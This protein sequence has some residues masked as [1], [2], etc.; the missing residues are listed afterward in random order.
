MKFRYINNIALLGF[1]FTACQ[2][3]SLSYKEITNNTISF[4][5]TVVEPTSLQTR[6]PS[7]DSTTFVTHDAF[8]CDFYLQLD[9]Q[10]SGQEITEF[11]TYVVPSTYEGRLDV[12]NI[13]GES[14][15]TALSWKSLRGEHTFYGWTFPTGGKQGYNIDNPFAN[16]SGEEF[17]EVLKNGVEITFNN[18]SEGK[19]YDTYNN[20]AIY[21]QFIGTQKGP[22]T[23]V[24]N[25]TYV[26]LIFKHLVSKIYVDEIV[27][28]MFGSIEEHLQANMTIY[29]LPTKATFYPNPKLAIDFDGE[30][31][32]NDGGPVVVP[33]VNPDDEMTFYIENDSK[34]QDYVWICP[35]V[36]FSD[37]SF[38]V[39]L[40]STES[41]YNGLKDFSGTFKNVIFDRTG[42]NWD[43][44]K[45]GDETVLHAGEMM[46]LK[47]ILYPGGD[48]GLYVK[49]LPW[50]THDPEDT[51]HYSHAGLYSDSSLNEIAAAADD[52]EKA[53]ELFELYGEE[54]TNEDGTVEKVFNLYENTDLTFTSGNMNVLRVT[55]DYVLEGNGH[56]I[57]VNKSNVR[58]R[59]VRNVYITDC[60][61]KYI[62]IDPDGKLYRVDPNTF[63]TIGEPFD[64]LIKNKST[65]FT[66]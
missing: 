19:D 60:K 20:N 30:N 40:Q 15:P 61:G 47:I 7:E 44:D 45:V 51:P 17:E 25:G 18:S 46:I 11:G 4:T 2:S 39:S 31:N 5:A 14:K 16:L 57:T 50:S 54:I 23:Y 43:N 62:Y 29:G 12:K 13:E 28:D 26:P 32:F 64:T 58:V 34:N 56:L 66:F 63:Q 9:T 41:G 42:I 53:A 48:G 8:D 65:D 36:D 59:N 10:N 21:E 55:N 35:E 52:K 37:L 49:I 6:V 38:N 24:E 3:E 22:V 27:L 1:L 33:N